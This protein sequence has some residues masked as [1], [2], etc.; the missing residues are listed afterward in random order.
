MLQLCDWRQAVAENS[1]V[2][3]FVDVQKAQVAV[4]ELAL[5]PPGPTLAKEMNDI[6]PPLFCSSYLPFMLS[7]EVAV[8]QRFEVVANL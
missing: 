6:I 5:V 8:L 3:V 1:S 7:I 4:S 2:C